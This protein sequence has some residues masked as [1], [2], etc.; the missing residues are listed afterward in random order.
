MKTKFLLSF[1]FSFAVLLASAQEYRIRCTVDSAYNGKSVFLVDRTSGDSINTAVVTE[2]SFSFE[3]KVNGGAIYDVIVNKAKGLSAMVLV[4][5]NTVAEVDFTDRPFEACDNGAPND[6]LSSYTND[7]KKLKADLREKCK[8][9]E[10]D[11][12]SE[13]EVE[14]FW[15]AGELAMFDTY[16]KVIKDNCNNLVGAV[17]LNSVARQLCTTSAS[18]DSAMSEV[19]YAGLLPSL[20]RLRTALYYG[21]KT[22]AGNPFIDFAGVSQDGAAVR[23]SDYVGKG[24]YVL[25]EFWASWCGP[26]QKEMPNVIAA[27]KKY[28][29]DKFMVVGVNISDKEDAFKDALP[30]FGITYPQIH[31]PRGGKEE[32]N[33]VLLYNVATIPHM[34]LIAPDGTILERDINGADLDEKISGCLK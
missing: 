1:I 9:M 16:R 15:E 12:K 20:S 31:V 27:D 13:K 24:K 26:C 4:E 29:G 19:K 18:L 10:A 6:R 17:L 32:N 7:F 34:M 8:Q 30:K 2:C 25:V 33:A 23:M 14:E 21:E 11:G 3:G 22:V 28:T 5:G